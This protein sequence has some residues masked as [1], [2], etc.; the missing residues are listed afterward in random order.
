MNRRG[1]TLKEFVNDDSKYE[2][3]Q[4]QAIMETIAWILETYM[5]ENKKNKT[6]LAGELSTSRSQLDKLLKPKAGNSKINLQ[7]IL[8]VG[9]VTGKKVDMVFG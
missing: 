7:T 8:R 3:I 5:E 2:E 6:Q 1:R 4:A 9:R